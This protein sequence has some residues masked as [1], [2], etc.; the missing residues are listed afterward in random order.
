MFIASML[1]CGDLDI[2]YINRIAEEYGVDFDDVKE[3]L[4]EYEE[5][6]ANNIIYCIM[7]TAGRMFLSRC[8]D[9]IEGLKLS[10]KAKKEALKKVEEFELNI[11]ENYLASSFDSCINDFIGDLSMENIKEFLLKAEILEEDQLWI[12]E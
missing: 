4:R 1:N 8:A 3:A 10:K 5:K 6:N 7:D 11:S 9:I 2:D 12:D